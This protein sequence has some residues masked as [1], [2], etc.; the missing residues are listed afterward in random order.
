MDPNETLKRIRTERDDFLNAHGKDN[1]AALHHAYDLVM[2][3]DDLDVWLSKGGFKPSEW[4]EPEPVPQSG[5]HCQIIGKGLVKHWE[6][7]EFADGTIT[8]V[9]DDGKVVYDPNGA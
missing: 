1:E 5:S 2:A 4:D 3:L 6:C 9:Y 8:N 7:D